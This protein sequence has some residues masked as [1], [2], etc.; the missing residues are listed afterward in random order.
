MDC[1]GGEFAILHGHYGGSSAFGTNAISDGI[2]VWKAGLEALVD[3]EEA[4][5]CCEAKVFSEPG[6]FLSDGF[7]DLVGLE[8]EFRAR[9][10]LWRRAAGR[11]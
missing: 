2:D 4:F 3:G 7:D 8:D 1:G 5:C 6:L 9:D 10:G 11:V